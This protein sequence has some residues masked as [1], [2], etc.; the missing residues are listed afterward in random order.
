MDQAADEFA[1]TFPVRA[2]AYYEISRNRLEDQA[3]WVG[4]LD[5]RLTATFSLSAVVV[6][7]FTAAMVIGQDKWPWHLI[8]LSVLVMSLFA[9]STFFGYLASRSSRWEERP[10]LRG[11]QTRVRLPEAFQWFMT[12]SDMVAAYY[13]NA[14]VIKKKEKWTKWAIRVTA[15]NALV[16]SVAAVVA[17]AFSE[18]KC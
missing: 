15:V 7:I 11:V 5:S 4:T 9:T 18:G 6:A 10:D 12:A 2:K 13:A 8:V 3:R 17:I 1:G 14:D 16:V